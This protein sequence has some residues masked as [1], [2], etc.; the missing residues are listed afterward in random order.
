MAVIQFSVA[1][2]REGTSAIWVGFIS[3]LNR[4]CDLPVVANYFY[5]KIKRYRNRDN[6]M[7]VLHYSYRVY[8]NAMTLCA[9][10]DIKR[11]LLTNW[12][13]SC[14][15]GLIGYRQRLARVFL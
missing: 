8:S 1:I 13:A 7:R 14:D 5:E 10:A 4:L 11:S 2:E 6:I 15:A 12:T 9:P 3:H